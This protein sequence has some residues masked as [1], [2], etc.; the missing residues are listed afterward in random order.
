MEHATGAESG[1]G[2]VSSQIVWKV[3]LSFQYVL[4]IRIQFQPKT[5]PNTN[6]NI[7]KVFL[8]PNIFKK[9]KFLQK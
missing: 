9:W 3:F 2:A 4:R 1:K 5:F 8:Q 7:G 6:P